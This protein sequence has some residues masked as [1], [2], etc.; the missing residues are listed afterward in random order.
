VAFTYPLFLVAAALKRLLGYP[1]EG[2]ARAV[3]VFAQARADVEASIA[4]AFMG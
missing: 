3:S 4:L 1:G 2:G